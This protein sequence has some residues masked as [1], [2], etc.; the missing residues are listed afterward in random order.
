[1]SGRRRTALLLLA[2]AAG[3]AAAQTDL[4]G[5][6]IGT[7]SGTFLKVP[8][9]ARTAALAGATSGHV[10][11][12]E[13]LFSNPA[14]LGIENARG[15]RFSAMEMPTGIPAGG[16]AVSFPFEPIRGAIGVGMT[17]LCAT[18][19][20]TDEYHPLGTGREFSYTALSVVLGLSRALTDK[21]NFG[22]ATKVF[23]E[24]MGTEVGGPNLTTWLFDAGAIYFVGY[25]DVRI[26]LALSNF[27]PDLTPSG[28]YTSRRNGTSID[29]ESFSPPTFFRFSFAGDPIS[30]ES[31]KLVTAIEIGHPA[32]NRE[33]LRLGAE[34][35]L[36]R[37]LFLRS[38]YDF[39]A[40]ELKMNAGV[41]VRARFG[42]QVFNVDYAYAAG[43][44][45]GDIH[46][47]T[48]GCLW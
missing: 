37:R 27:G 36:G 11:G 31:W 40:D 14:G 8:V 28:A 3:P 20:E 26:G 1:M 15:V 38:G 33:A 24:G 44:Y 7:S 45:F 48:V 23:R 5:Q 10:R 4:G 19:D 16:I 21:L 2:L 42:E 34:L 30:G 41:G 29:Y 39:S 18:M 25:R 9:D 17:G 6:R 47:W 46:R 35:D 12:P 32:D 22:V 43:D 13:A